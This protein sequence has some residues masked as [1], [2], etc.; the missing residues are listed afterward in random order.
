MSTLARREAPARAARLPWSRYRLR[1]LLWETLRYA[2]LLAFLAVFLVPFFWVWATAL[3]SPLDIAMNP[4]GLPSELHW[5]NLAQAW[6]VGHFGQYVAN[7]ALYC[8]TI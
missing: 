1:R 8:V 2:V 7:S 5:E 6:T 3:K 4:F